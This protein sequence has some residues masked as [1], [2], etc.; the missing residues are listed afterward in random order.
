[1]LIKNTTNVLDVLKGF[2]LEQRKTKLI[3]IEQLE[4]ESLAVTSYL[5]SK[6]YRFQERHIVSNIYLRDDDFV[7]STGSFENIFEI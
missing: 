2:S 4:H 5:S 7:P 6:G 1:L 3:C